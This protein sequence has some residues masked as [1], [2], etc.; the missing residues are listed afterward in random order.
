[1]IGFNVTLFYIFAPP[2][3]TF[4]VPAASLVMLVWCCH[5][6]AQQYGGARACMTARSNRHAVLRW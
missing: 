6:L 2:T 3:A 5:E 1:M 4:V